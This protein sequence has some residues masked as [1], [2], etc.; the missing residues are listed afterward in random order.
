MVAFYPGAIPRLNEGDTG[1][2]VLGFAF[3]LTALSAVTFSALPAWQAARDS[4]TGM[5]RWGGARMTQHGRR[6]ASGLVGIQVAV[7]TVVLITAGLLFKS[8]ALLRSLDPG[9]A[10]EQILTAQIVLPEA[11]YPVARD[12]AVFAQAWVGRLNAIPGIEAAAVTNS[13]PLAFNFLLSLD[14]NVPGIDGEQNVGA[15]AVTGR[16]FDVMGLQLQSGRP[17]TP[18][19]DDRKDVVVV[20]E[21]FANRFFPDGGAVGQPLRFG[22]EL[23]TIVGVVKDLRNLRIQR[24]AQPEL[25]LPFSVIPAVFLDMAMRVNSDPSSIVRAVRAEL[26][27]MDSGLALAQVGSM[28]QILDNSVAQPRSQAILMALFASVAML[29]A[30]VG[31]YGVI[32]ESV[33]A[34]TAEFGVRKAL[35]AKSGDLFRLVLRQGMRAPLLGLAVGLLG[36]MASGRMVE[37]FLFG[38]SSHD[39]VVFLAAPVLLTTVAL[40]ACLVPARY[41]ARVDPS[42]AL[43]QE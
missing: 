23:R 19:D 43:R 5:W 8:F 27:S 4:H 41:A 16:F 31:T 30:A 15:R 26:R 22:S 3:V 37:S 17:L 21:S 36:G 14:V 42:Q 18:A 12:Q 33:T 9:F 24:P 38:V 20:N 32:A 35:G 29:L 40:V 10:Q 39:R 11:R 1:W 7:T 6:W 28:E 2:V 25:Y 13:L 34:R